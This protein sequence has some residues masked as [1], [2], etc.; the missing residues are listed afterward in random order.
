MGLGSLS[1]YPIL[2]VG[3]SDSLSRHGTRLS[4]S[5]SHPGTR[6]FL[7]PLPTWDSALFQPLPSWDSA[8]LRAS[9]GMGLVFLLCCLLS[10]TGERVRFEAS[11]SS[12]S[13]RPNGRQYHKDDEGNKW[14]EIPA[15]SQP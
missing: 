10:V 3:Y 5:L 14:I 12:E 8:F 1:A 2:G 15:R 9:S 4:F 11:V 13:R 6:L 7:Q